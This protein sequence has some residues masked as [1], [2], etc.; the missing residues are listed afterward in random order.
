MSEY[1]LILVWNFQKKNWNNPNLQRFCE[2]PENLHAC[3]SAC[4]PHILVSSS[5]LG[6]FVQRRWYRTSTQ[7]IFT[8]AAAVHSLSG[9]EGVLFMSPCDK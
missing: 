9:Q 7:N 4:L 3:M 8:Q 1:D 2:I 5:D 6:T